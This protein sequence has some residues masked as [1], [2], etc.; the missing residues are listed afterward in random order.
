MHKIFAPASHM[1]LVR[2]KGQYDKRALFHPHKEGDLV[3]LDDPAQKH[4]K[5]ATIVNMS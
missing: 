3:L 5:L 4:N 1:S 2:Q